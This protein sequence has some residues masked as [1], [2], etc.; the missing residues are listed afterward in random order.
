M[1]SLILKKFKNLKFGFLTL[2]MMFILV[3][4]G[5]DCK[6]NEITPDTLVSGKLNTDYSAKIDQ[7]SSCS[8]TAKKVEV[9]EGSLPP[10]ITLEGNGVLS[11]KP[12]NIG[13]YTFTVKFEVCFGT[14]A[15]GAT[16]CTEKT[17]SFTIVIEN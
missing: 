4:C 10:G 6:F 17:K 2:I 1:N 15:Y 7:S 3:S 9:K 12:T 13:S 16:N 8:Y 14:S 11:G 5:N